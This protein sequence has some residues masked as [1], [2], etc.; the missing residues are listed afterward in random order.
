MG[1]I[2]SDMHYGRLCFSP[3]QSPLP[4]VSPSKGPTSPPVVSTSSPTSSPTTTSH[5]PT[6]APVTRHQQQL[7]EAAMEEEDQQH[8]HAVLLTILAYEHGTIACSTI[9][10]LAEQSLEVFST[11]LKG[12]FS[13]RICKT[14]TGNRK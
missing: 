10:V 3:T 6:A 8:F 4:T 12:H 11:C 7:A 13:I 1:A 14:S 2:G 5:S 9:T